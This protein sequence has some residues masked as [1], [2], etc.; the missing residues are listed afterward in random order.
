MTYE[1]VKI[2]VINTEP[3]KYLWCYWVF[4]WAVQSCSVMD[5]VPHPAQKNDTL[6]KWYNHIRQRLLFCCTTFVATPFIYFTLQNVRQMPSTYQ[7]CMSIPS[8]VSLYRSNNSGNFTLDNVDVL[9]HHAAFLT[10]ENTQKSRLLNTNI[11]P[12]CMF[13]TIQNKRQN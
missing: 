1:Q 6:G 7:W 10:D 2:I 13:L 9:V 4:P 8:G 5:P 11:F 3:P 12:F